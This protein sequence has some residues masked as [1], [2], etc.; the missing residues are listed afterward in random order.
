MIGWPLRQQNWS[1]RTL[2]SNGFDFR[3]ATWSEREG[4]MVFGGGGVRMTDDGAGKS[5]INGTAVIKVGRD[6]AETR[7]A[8]SSLPPVSKSGRK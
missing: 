2:S 5:G 6:S 1:A 4:T 8:I 3:M 7:S